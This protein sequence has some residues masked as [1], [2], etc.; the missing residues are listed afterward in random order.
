MLGIRHP[1]IVNV[2]ASITAWTQ[3][4]PVV[5]PGGYPPPNPA[6]PMKHNDLWIAATAHAIGATLVSTDRDFDHLDGIW[7]RF[8]YVDQTS[9]SD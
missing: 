8:R 1:S 9:R 3:R 6:V 7:L 5:G 2:Y 4:G